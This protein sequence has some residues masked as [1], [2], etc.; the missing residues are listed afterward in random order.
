[1]ISREFVSWMAQFAVIQQAE[2]K[3]IWLQHD[4]NSFSN[5]NFTTRLGS[6]KFIWIHFER[7]KRYGKI[8]KCIKAEYAHLVF[9]SK[10]WLLGWRSSQEISQTIGENLWKY[11][12]SQLNIVGGYK[13][14]K[15][16]I[17]SV[18]LLK[19]PGTE[20]CLHPKQVG[21]PCRTW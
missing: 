11:F 6:S 19:G 13:D 9:S 17:I 10:T 16:S 20:S 12:R 14:R 3:R 2:D 1:M 21:I 5:Y 15:N 8:L 7:R 4:Y 18:E